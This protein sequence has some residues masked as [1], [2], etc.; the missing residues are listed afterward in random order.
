MVFLY[1]VLMP[2][3]WPPRVGGT[4]TNLYPPP[5]NLCCDWLLQQD[6]K[7]ELKETWRIGLFFFFFYFLSFCFITATYRSFLPD[8]EETRTERFNKNRLNGV[9]SVF[10]R[11]RGWI[12]KTTAI[13]SETISTN[14]CRETGRATAGRRGAAWVD[15]WPGE[16][17]WQTHTRPVHLIHSQDV[18]KNK[19]LP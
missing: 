12:P 2:P 14:T 17:Q 19:S 8:D 6:D 18:G 15:C 9:T 3:P 16:S 7:L 4:Q 10:L 11:W 13:C 5:W 1:V